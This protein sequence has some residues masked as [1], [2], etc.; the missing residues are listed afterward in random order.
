M[1]LA[2]LWN[3]PDNTPTDHIDSWCNRWTHLRGKFVA[4]SSK[5]ICM[6]IHALN[7][8]AAHNTVSILVETTYPILGKSES[9]T[10]CDQPHN[11]FRER[12]RDEP[13]AWPLL[14]KGPLDKRPWAYYKGT[15]WKILFVNNAN[16][17]GSSCM[18]WN[19]VMY[20]HKKGMI[21]YFVVSSKAG[22]LFK[23]LKKKSKMSITLYPLWYNSYNSS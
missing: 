20:L 19:E 15:F 11:V 6:W 13:N 22:V 14:R 17:I 2:F 1:S 4:R 23:K 21:L 16:S 18:L 12:L 8:A 5:R 10:Y 3:T 9:Y 7:T